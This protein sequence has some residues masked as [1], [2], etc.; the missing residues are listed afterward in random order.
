MLKSQETSPVGAQHVAPS[1]NSHKFF[2]RIIIVLILLIGFALRIYRLDAVDLTGDEAFTAVY[3]LYAPFSP[4]WFSTMRTEPNPGALAISWAMTSLSGDSVFVLRLVSVFG[5]MIG[6]AS[7]MA[8]A[9]RLFRNWRLVALVGVLWALNP[10]LIYY[11]QDARQYGLI[12]GFNPLSFYLFLRALDQKTPRAWL[13]YGVVQ[14]IA[15][16]VHFLD[17][18][19]VAAQV[20]FVFANIFISRKGDPA[21]RPYTTMLKDI[22]QPL[23]TWLLMGV[24]LIPL[25]IQTYV[26]VVVSSY[27]ANATTADLG[28]LFSHFLP[29][30]LFGENTLPLVIG[31]ILAVVLIGSLIVWSRQHPREGRLLLLWLLVPTILFLII[32][33]QASLFRP[34]Y[35]IALT[36]ALILAIGTFADL[37]RRKSAW[38]GA[39]MA[40]ICVVSALEVRD[41]Y[42]YDTPK[43]AD[44][45][46]LTA[47][48]ESRA[49]PNDTVIFAYSDPAMNY[50]YH[51]D[52]TFVPVGTPNI[53]E[54]METLLT[55]YDALFL[56]PGEGMD[57][58][59][60]YLQ[61][62]AQWIPNDTHHNVTQYRSWLVNEREIQFPMSVD[63]G[64]VGRLR[65]YSLVQGAEGATTLLLYWEALSQTPDDYSIMLHLQVGD[66]PPIVLDHGVAN[67]Q[68]STRAWQIGTLYRDPIMIPLET[69][70]GEYTIYVG[71]YPV[72]TSDLLEP[73]RYEIGS[74][75]LTGN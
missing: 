70:A 16:Y 44:W 52:V 22:K 26:V 66:A 41:Y 53:P 39:V 4:A 18:L 30:L 25:A 71:M 51:S 14:T 2:T 42:F 33:T 35:V 23:I 72:G 19:W 50:Y 27:R 32:T 17:V 43:G 9:R 28:A 69:P 5:G 31:V 20:I 36:P 58:A 67:A 10:F 45:R 49:T 7:G 64:D 34:R 3:G 37:M 40:G 59:Q 6:L 61:A 68:I 1:S 60:V 38:I 48:L 13:M 57:I 62:H 54:L 63:F 56:L 24:A 47:Y 73:G 74:I 11:A 12:S 75:N 29:T 15:I 8:L 21:G 55:S 65:G 46:G